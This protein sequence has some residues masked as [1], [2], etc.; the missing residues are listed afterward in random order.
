MYLLSG[1]SCCKQ[2]SCWERNQETRA[3]WRQHVTWAPSHARHWSDVIKPWRTWWKPIFVTWHQD[4]SNWWQDRWHLRPNTA[5][6]ARG[7]WRHPVTTKQDVTTF[8]TR[9]EAAW[10]CDRCY[11]TRKSDTK[12][13]VTCKDI[14]YDVQKIMWET[15]LW[16]EEQVQIQGVIFLRPVTCD[17]ARRHKHPC[18]VM[19][20]TLYPT[21][22]CFQMSG[23]SQYSSK[24]R[25]PGHVPLNMTHCTVV[26]RCPPTVRE[27]P[28]WRKTRE[29]NQRL[30]LLQDGIQLRFHARSILRDLFVVT[31]RAP[32]HTHT[33]HKS[34][35]R[36]A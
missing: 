21:L 27:K 5:V 9:R 2:H 1:A 36:H 17:H 33:A 4:G 14:G 22:V 6:T 8:V 18:T 25:L 30:L 10:A 31:L 12:L 24:G 11:M 32:A 15:K 34:A 29:V 13:A 3:G 20:R 26:R 28:C 19:D 16:G 23:D 35:Q 7:W